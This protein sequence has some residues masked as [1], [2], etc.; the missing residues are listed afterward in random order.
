MTDNIY[1]YVVPL[2]EGINEAVCPCIDGYTIYTA[3]RLNGDATRAAFFHALWHI[4]NRDFETESSVSM[5]E[6]IAHETNSK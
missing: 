6:I 3:D 2:P 4:Y 5:K 1:H